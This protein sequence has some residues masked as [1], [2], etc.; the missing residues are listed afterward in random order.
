MLEMYFILHGAQ[1][2]LWPKTPSQL[3]TGVETILSFEY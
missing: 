1:M 2:T 3:E